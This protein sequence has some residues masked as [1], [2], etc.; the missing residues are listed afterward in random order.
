MWPVTSSHLERGGFEGKGGKQGRGGINAI[1]MTS[2]QESKGNSN[3]EYIM[4]V[5]GV[6]L[7]SRASWSSTSFV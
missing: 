5:S 7:N 1:N 2:D 3:G 4:E 6:G